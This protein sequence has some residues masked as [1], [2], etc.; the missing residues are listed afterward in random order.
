MRTMSPSRSVSTRAPRRSENSRGRSTP[1]GAIARRFGRGGV[2]HKEGGSLPTSVRKLGEQ[3]LAARRPTAQRRHVGSLSS[4]ADEDQALRIDAILKVCPLRLPP[5]DVRA[6][7]L[8]SYH[9]FFKFSFSAWRGA[10]KD[11]RHD[12]GERKAGGASSRMCRSTLPS[13]RAIAAK[14]ATRRWSLRGRIADTVGDNATRHSMMQNARSVQV[15]GPVSTDRHTRPGAGRT[16]GRPG[17]NC[18]PTR[19]SNNA[20]QGFARGRS[21]ALLYGRRHPHSNLETL[22]S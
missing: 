17:R 9:A 6:T 15:A 21:H 19:T 13:R 10:I 20:C 7:A 22:E 1:D 12:A 4:L 18:A 14:L 2:Q 11:C 5:H 3:A 16:V 8:A